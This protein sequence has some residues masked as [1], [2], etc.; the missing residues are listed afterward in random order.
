MFEREDPG[1]TGAQYSDQLAKFHALFSE[2]PSF[3]AVL[4]G[5][6]HRFVA[7]N[8]AYQR[9]IGDRPVIG[10]TVA[11]ALPE[12]ASQDYLDLLGRVFTSGEPYVGRAM[13][14]LIDRVEGAGPE[15]RFVDFVY[16]PVRA[17][18]GAVIAIFVEGT[19]VTDAQA[20]GEQLQRSEAWNR[21]ILDAATDH[22]IIALDP[23]GQVTRWNA[24]AE[25][26]LGW[27]EAEMVGRSA[28]CI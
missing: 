18:D 9:L 15:R 2:S 6:D 10:R 17:A 24:G 28:S 25:A 22:A 3:A 11:E 27:T 12:V 21:Q 7:T 23:D 19:D 5:R 14:L 16:Q 26:I 1:R 8:P 13:P 20:A 4:G